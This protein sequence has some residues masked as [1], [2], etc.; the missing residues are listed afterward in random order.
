M[1]KQLVDRENTAAENDDDDDDEDPKNKLVYSCSAVLS[2]GSACSAQN[3]FS[4]SVSVN[5]RFFG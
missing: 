2:K 5:F 3:L 4:T 1:E